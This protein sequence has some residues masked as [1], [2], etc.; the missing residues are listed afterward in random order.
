MNRS[1][2]VTGAFTSYK[3][4]SLDTPPT[5]DDKLMSIS[6]WVTTAQC[7]RLS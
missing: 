1:W 2:H 5:A 3:Y 6:K 4:W 7:V